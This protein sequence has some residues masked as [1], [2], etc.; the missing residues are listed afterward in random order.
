MSVPNPKTSI[1]DKVANLD[2]LIKVNYENYLITTLSNNLLKFLFAQPP[3]LIIF[4]SFLYREELIETREDEIWE[5]FFYFESTYPISIN[6][7]QLA[8]YKFRV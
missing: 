3:T 4:R 1:S 2:Y 6:Q 5:L 8:E 7:N